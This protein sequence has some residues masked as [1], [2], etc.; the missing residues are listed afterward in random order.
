MSSDKEQQLNELKELDEK[1]AALEMKIQTLNNEKH[2]LVS[3]LKNMLLEE[4]KR[5]EEERMLQEQ[6]LYVSI[7][8]NFLFL[9]FM[10]NY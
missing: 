2:N 8:P 6:R 10:A 9:L 7:S 3:T 4:K 5:E 1:M